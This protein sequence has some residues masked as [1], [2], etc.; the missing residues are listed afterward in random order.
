MKGLRRLMSNTRLAAA[1]DAAVIAARERASR[2][3]NDP[4]TT[5]ASFAALTN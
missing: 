2:C 3:A 1:L 5:T 4:Y